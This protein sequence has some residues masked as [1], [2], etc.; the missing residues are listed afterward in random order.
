MMARDWRCA[1]I[2]AVLCALAPALARAETTVVI[3]TVP[4]IG[5]APLICADVRGYFKDEGIA[6]DVESFRIARDMIPLVARG[7]LKLIGGSMNVSYFN[8]VARG[9]PLIYVANRAQSP[10]YH[11]LMV[12]DDLAAAITAPKDLKGR[13]IGLTGIGS[14]LDYEVAMVLAAGGLQ[15]SDVE[16]K[17]VGF[18][19]MAIAFQNK[20]IDAGI[21]VSPYIEVAEGEGAR[22]WVDPEIYIKRPLEVS[23]LMANTEW[24]GQNEDLL[25]RFMVAFIKGV[26]CYLEA[27][28]LGPNRGELIDALVE[29]TPIKDRKVYETMVWPGINPDARVLRDSVLALQDFFI[30]QGH[31]PERLPIGR[32]VDERYVEAALAQIGPAASPKP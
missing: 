22:R 7:D 23:G 27:A 16:I 25:D 19:E 28:A 31:L 15:W 11:N 20:A 4:T 30:A 5:D 18:P 9:L 10:A 24:A 26:R 21:L 14:I 32:L 1:L 12:R 13:A 8:A 17:D 6:L 3:G 2:L 29:R